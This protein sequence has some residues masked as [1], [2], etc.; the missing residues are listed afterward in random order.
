MDQNELNQIPVKEF[1]ENEQIIE[2]PICREFDV[3]Y[4]LNQN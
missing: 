1:T 3:F 4:I 2:D